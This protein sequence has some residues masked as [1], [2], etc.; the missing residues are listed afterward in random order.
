MMMVMMMM[1]V[2]VV[3]IMVMMMDQMTDMG[4]ADGGMWSVLS[5]VWV[6]EWVGLIGSPAAPARPWTARPICTANTP[7]VFACGKE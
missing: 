1:M 3:M 5:R 7:P 4:G 2:V 6:L